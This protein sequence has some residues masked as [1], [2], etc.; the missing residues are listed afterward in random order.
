M[1]TTET[2]STSTLQQ[3]MNRGESFAVF[4]I[5][6]KNAFQNWLIQGNSLQGVNVPYYDFKENEVNDTLLRND[7]TVIFLPFADDT[8][9]KMMERLS[10]KG[11]RIMELLG[12]WQEWS[13]FYMTSTVIKSPEMKLIQ[14]HRLATGCLSYIL[15]TGQQCAVIDPSIHVDQYLSMADREHAKVT[16][17]LETHVHADHLSGAPELLRRTSARYMISH[18]DIHRHALDIERLKRGTIHIGSTD[19]HVMI[20]DTEGETRGNSLFVI[21]QAILSGDTISVGEVGI[22]DMP[23][24]AKEWAEKL[25]NTVFRDVSGLSDDLLIL[26]AHFADIQAVNRSGYVGAVL[27]DLR[28]G[29]EAMTRV[30]L[31]H[32]S[33]RPKDFVAALHPISDDI[34]EMNLGLKNFDLV[35]GLA[36]EREVRA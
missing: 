24:V 4:D 3:R 6:S 19:I 26:P 17:I 9:D 28:L 21:D 34:K 11:Y 2:I 18:A 25:F 12:G 13:N 23:G 32:F 36:A 1:R 15:I 20:L 29:S 22:P 5:R 16:H 35:Q 8:Q 33:Q 14:V 27:A 10:Q 31:T 7:T 30:S